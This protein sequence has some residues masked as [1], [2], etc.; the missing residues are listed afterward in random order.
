[1]GGST[2]GKPLSPHQR[3]PAG[4]RA[5]ILTRKDP[6][7]LHPRAPCSGPAAAS[8]TQCACVCAKSLQP[9]LTLRPM[10]YNCQAPPPMGFSRQEYWSRLPFPS[11]GDPPHP[12]VER[13]SLL[14]PALQTGSL[15]LSHLGSTP[16]TVASGICR[17]PGWAV[18]VW[19]RS[20]QAAPALLPARCFSQPISRCPQGVGLSRSPHSLWKAE[21]GSQKGQPC[22]QRPQLTGCRARAQDQGSE[23]LVRPLRPLGAA[24]VWGPLGLQDTPP[25][26]GPS[27]DPASTNSCLRQTPQ[28]RELGGAAHSLQNPLL[29]S[30]QPPGAPL[31]K[32]ACVISSHSQGGSWRALNCTLPCRASF[33]KQVNKYTNRG[34]LSRWPAP[35]G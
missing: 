1:M 21:E 12:G 26:P 27:G 3:A 23:N 29:P 28:C 19:C 17:Q 30:P 22:A 6:I 35:A 11:P 33:P 4:P 10:D 7:F 5:C 18:R 24:R 13:T 2:Q 31:E 34:Q 16:A 15:P 32:N 9:C 20:V 14:S 25:G 8:Q